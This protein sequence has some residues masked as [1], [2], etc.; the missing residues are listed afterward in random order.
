ME[1]H[2]DQGSEGDLALRFEPRTAMVLRLEGRLQ[3]A[4]QAVLAHTDDGRRIATEIAME[5]HAHLERT[6]TEEVHAD[7]LRESRAQ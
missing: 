4:A 3:T 6:A 2:G 1:A 7:P 5:E